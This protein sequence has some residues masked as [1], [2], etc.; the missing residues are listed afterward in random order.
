MTA[1]DSLLS[2]LAA[3][4]AKLVDLTSPLSPTTPVLQLPEPF[5]N[6]ISMSL[7]KVSDFD[8]D[9]PFWGWNNLH[10][11]EHTGTHLDAPVHWASGRDGKSVD[12]I[13]PA[14]LVGPAVVLDFTA[15]AA[16]DADFLLGP[17]H[18][19]KYVAENG[20]L[21]EG[22]WLILRTGWSQYNEDAERFAN[23]DENGPHT[24]G[25]SVEGA[26]WLAA[27]PISGFGVETVGID[28]GQAATMDPA[29]PVHYF[30]L[31]ADKYGLTSLQNVDQL[32]ETGAVIVVAPLPIVGGTGAPARVFAFAPA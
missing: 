16:A 28:A 6:T 2:A 25:V 19:D 3:G 12:R 17:E 30:L 13:E 24:P 20:P 1:I 15:E 27:S 11:G 18:L 7:E 22:C 8:D 29:F 31:G 14:R 26:Q 23:A 4:E 5:A 21:P 10:T 9:G 32:P